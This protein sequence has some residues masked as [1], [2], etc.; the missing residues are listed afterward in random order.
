[1]ASHVKSMNADDCS[2]GQGISGELCDLDRKLACRP[3][4]SLTMPAASLTCHLS[5]LTVLAPCWI[6]SQAPF[7]SGH[8][9]CLV[10]CSGT[11]SLGAQLADTYNV[12]IHVSKASGSTH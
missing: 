4:E 6:L 7:F 3:A 10:S 1:M 9:A 8:A 5:G 2:R 11:C 12:M